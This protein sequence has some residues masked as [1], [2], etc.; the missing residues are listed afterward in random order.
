MQ[1]VQVG[2]KA[3]SQPARI[4]FAVQSFV[5]MENDHTRK[6]NLTCSTGDDNEIEGVHVSND[7]FLFVVGKKR[8]FLA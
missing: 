3:V 1:R 7:S 6:K 5:T 2:K 8:F 4:Q